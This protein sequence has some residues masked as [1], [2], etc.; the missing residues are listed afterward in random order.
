MEE[1]FRN[2]PLVDLHKPECCTV[3]QVIFIFAGLVAALGSEEV[4]DSLH[5]IS[6]VSQTEIGKATIRTLKAI[7][8]SQNN[9]GK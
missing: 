2:K 8:S 4:K 9:S 1:R 7:A 3:C 6:V 5:F